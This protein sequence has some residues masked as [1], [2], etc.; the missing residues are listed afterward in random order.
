MIL[1]Y[2]F[3]YLTHSFYLFTNNKTTKTKTTKITKMMI[4]ALFYSDITDFNKYEEIEIDSSITLGKLEEIYNQFKDKKFILTWTGIKGE[5]IPFFSNKNITIDNIIKDY[6]FKKGEKIK[7]LVMEYKE[8]REEKKEK[9][10]REEKETLD[11]TKKVSNNNNDPDKDSGELSQSEMDQMVKEVKD[12]IRAEGAKKLLTDMDK[13]R[14]D[15]NISNIHLLLNE[16]AKFL[17]KI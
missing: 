16:I 12:D 9:K 10:E 15:G 2:G 6:P 14:R 5:K 17:H 4:R 1:K 3:V 11:G 13:F 7:F 8:I